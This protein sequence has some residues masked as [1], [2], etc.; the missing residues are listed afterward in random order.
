MCDHR[1]LAENAIR[2]PLD[3]VQNDVSFQDRC[4]ALVV[5]I[6]NTC[7]NPTQLKRLAKTPL[8]ASKYEVEIGF[9]TTEST[10]LCARYY[11]LIAELRRQSRDDSPLKLDTLCDYL[12]VLTM[13]VP[14]F[15][16][17]QKALQTTIYNINRDATELDIINNTINSFLHYAYLQTEGLT[18]SS[19]PRDLGNMI[20]KIIASDTKDI[21]DAYASLY[22]SYQ[23]QI[24]PDIHQGIIEE[25]TYELE[26]SE[27]LI[28]PS[29]AHVNITPVSVETETFEAEATQVVCTIATNVSSSSESDQSSCITSSLTRRA[30]DK[31]RTE[32]RAHILTKAVRPLQ[33]TSWLIS[34]PYSARII[35]LQKS[36]RDSAL[37]AI[38]HLLRPWSRPREFKDPTRI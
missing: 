37:R 24:D 12:Q 33:Q 8:K 4:N 25:F 17:I 30:S 3:H 28:I 36:V 34:A 21:L 38:Q 22:S 6:F 16:N 15:H 29:P 5:G 35:R 9:V 7:F 18:G 31:S 14:L 32:Q 23:S 13:Y 11:G 10:R 26:E 27:E 2:A 19:K 1:I 20:R